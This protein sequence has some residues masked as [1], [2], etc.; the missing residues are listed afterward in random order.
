MG[1]KARLSDDQ[2]QAVAN[3]IKVPLSHLKAVAEVESRGFGFLPDGRPKILFEGHK[4]HKFTKGKFSR[5]NPVVSHRGWTRKYYRMDQYARLEEA[6]ALDREAALMSASWGKFQVMGFNWKVCK[7]PSLQ[8][9]INDMFRS[10]LGHLRSFV[11]FITTNKL[12]GPL[13]EGDFDRFA[14]RYNGKGYKLNKYAR[15]MRALELKFRR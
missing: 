4:F 13:R 14:L 15:K 9:F 10:E 5:T 11:G 2:L 12:I 6:V 1:R 3:Q 7:Y 8:K